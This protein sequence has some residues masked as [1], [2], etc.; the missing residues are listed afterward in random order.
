MYKPYPL[1]STPP[2]PGEKNWIDEAGRPVDRIIAVDGD[3]AFCTLRRTDDSISPPTAS[4]WSRW[5]KDYPTIQTVRRTAH[6]GDTI[7][8]V[9]M[10]AT[11]F[12][13]VWPCSDLSSGI[14]WVVATPADRSARP[15]L[16]LDGK[17]QVRVL[18][19]EGDYRFV[20]PVD[21]GVPASVNAARVTTVDR[22][23]I[24]TFQK[25]PACYGE[26]FISGINGG[27]NTWKGNDGPSHNE[28]WVKIG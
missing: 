5:H 9:D 13:V 16:V 10:R 19:T 7:L 3:S 21:G 8:D 11:A 12:E 20:I 15:T 23:A 25:R 28:R 1:N 4:L 26:Q 6:E 2:Q 24:S 18:A 17:T 22:P 14:Y 27:L